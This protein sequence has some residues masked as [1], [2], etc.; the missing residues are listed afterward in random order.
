MNIEIREARLGDEKSFARIQTESWKAAFSHILSPEE[1]A[2]CTQLTGAEE[3]YRR[4][5]AEGKIR[6]ALELVEGEPHCIAA[7]GMNRCNQGMHTAELICIHSLP[8]RWHQGYGSK[9]MRHVLEDMA[10]AG[11]S[12]VI[13][14]VFEENQQARKFYE[15]HG[16][17]STPTL[18][19]SHGAWERMYQKWL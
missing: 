6:L 19:L 9:M 7:W 15:K 11:F 14:W 3:M 1:L 12:K 4:V 18:N 10:Q 8:N 2:R 17:G 5:L 13:L 16:F